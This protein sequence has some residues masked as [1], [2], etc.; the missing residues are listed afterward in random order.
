[1]GGSHHTIAD[2]E[3]PV[4]DM[5]QGPGWWIASDGKWYPPEE[6]PDRTAAAE[7]TSAR[8][9]ARWLGR[10]E[11]SAPPWATGPDVSATDT[12]D[13]SSSGDAPAATASGEAPAVPVSPSAVGPPL[14]T[15]AEGQVFDPSVHVRE[16]RSLRFWVLG[17]VVLVALAVAALV[18]AL[19]SPAPTGTALSSGPTTASI[20]VTLPRTGHPSFSGTLAGRSLTGVISGNGEAS[21]TTGGQ[22]AEY[23]G[24]L[25]NVPFDLHVS[26]KPFQSGQLSFGVTGTYGSEPVTATA[27]FGVASSTSRSLSVPF[28]GHVGA[29]AIN[30]VATATPT[31]GNGVQI[32]ATLSVLPS[33]V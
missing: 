32:R 33:S 8:P 27:Q 29:Q 14:L 23:K 19:R 12:P 7:A 2:E 26:I 18:V 25:G 10:T 11:Q 30:G 6:H 1:M 3:A 22:I 13:A 9:A 5:S 16:A 28:N 31:S 24:T 21:A 4:S 17:A 15:T 20:D